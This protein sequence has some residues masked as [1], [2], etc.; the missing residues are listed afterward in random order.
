[1]GAGRG[2]VPTCGSGAVI[3]FGSFDED[4]VVREPNIDQTLAMNVQADM[5]RDLGW[6]KTLCRF[7]QKT[8]DFERALFEGQVE[9]RVLFASLCFTRLQYNTIRY[10]YTHARIETK[11][12]ESIRQTSCKN[13]ASKTKQYAPVGEQPHF[14]SVIRR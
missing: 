8:R 9:Q 1:M 3:V 11:I 5:A 12:K 2:A 6:F 4:V 10:T 7:A 13:Q 14:F